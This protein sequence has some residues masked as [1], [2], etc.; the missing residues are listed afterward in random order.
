MDVMFLSKED[1]IA[2]HHTASVHVFFQNFVLFRHAHVQC[3]PSQRSESAPDPTATL[4][5][6]NDIN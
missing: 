1:D 3:Y 5:L 4:E 2:L 6:K